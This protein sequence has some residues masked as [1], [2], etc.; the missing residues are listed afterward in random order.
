MLPAEISVG[1]KVERM[2]KH[3]EYDMPNDRF[4]III[5][6]LY[7]CSFTSST[8]IQEL[9]FHIHFFTSI[10]LFGYLA[11]VQSGRLTDSPSET[12]VSVFKSLYGLRKHKP[13][14]QHISAQVC[15]VVGYMQCSKYPLAHTYQQQQLAHKTQ[16]HFLGATQFQ[17]WAT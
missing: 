5:H 9:C 12:V 1:R 14:L 10:Q 4:F 2:T 3:T 13:Y 8:L 16:L 15:W 7:F 17:Q 11:V 6:I